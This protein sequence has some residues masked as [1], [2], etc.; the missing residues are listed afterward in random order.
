MY[1]YVEKKQNNSCAGCMILMALVLLFLAGCLSMCSE[2]PEKV[3]ARQDSEVKSFLAEKNL[4]LDL[5]AADVMT[6]KEFR[7][8]AERSR[9]IIDPAV[10]ERI[11]ALDAGYITLEQFKSNIDLIFQEDGERIFLECVSET[12]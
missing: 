9:S 2:S 10:S 1:N 8:Y 4:A 3:K 11:A 12:K 6:Q 7:C 5:K